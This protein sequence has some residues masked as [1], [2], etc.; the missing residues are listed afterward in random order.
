MDTANI[1][2][3][4]FK[5]D[6][7]GEEGFLDD[8]WTLEVKNVAQNDSRLRPYFE[9]A[10]YSDLEISIAGKA[11]GVNEAAFQTALEVLPDLHVY[12]KRLS[13]EIELDTENGW[14]HLCS[15]WFPY[16]QEKMWYL[17]FWSEY[18]ADIEYCYVKKDGEYIG[19]FAH[20]G[21]VANVLPTIKYVITELKQM[22]VDSSAFKDILEKIASKETIGREFII[23]LL[24]IVEAQKSREHKYRHLVKSLSEIKC[25]AVA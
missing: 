10:N 22:R 14:W 17:H 20:N 21:S 25:N 5:R 1:K 7:S 9:N 23:P 6:L 11:A 8:Y 18:G 2:K 19:C 15:I 13:S 16:Q 12:L 4:L 24:S 3:E